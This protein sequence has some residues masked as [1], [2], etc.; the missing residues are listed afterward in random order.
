MSPTKSK[1]L[2]SVFSGPLKISLLY[3]NVATVHTIEQLL[4]SI[5]LVI[6][7]II[8]NWKNRFTKLIV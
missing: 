2:Q 8:K 5:I 3:S 1:S 7:S 6:T 4:I